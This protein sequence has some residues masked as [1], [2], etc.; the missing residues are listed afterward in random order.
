MPCFMNAA[1]EVLVD[2]FLTGQISWKD[3]SYKLENLMEKHQTHLPKHY[4]ELAN[5]DM[6]A[7]QLAQRI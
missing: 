3:I 6:Q 7:R 4:D 1:N 5:I 2:R